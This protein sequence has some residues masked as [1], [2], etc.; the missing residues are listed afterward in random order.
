LRRSGSIPHERAAR[1]APAVRA[2][3]GLLAILPALLVGAF[4]LHSL[5]REQDLALIDARKLASDQAAALGAAIERSLL[6]PPLPSAADLR[7][8]QSRPGSPQR[9]PST[10]AGPGSFAL[11]IASDFAYPDLSDTPPRP[12]PF[13]PESLPAPLARIWR[14]ASLSSGP[15]SLAAWNEL[16]RLSSGTPWEPIVTFR[17]G[18]TLLAHGRT[19]EAADALD[20]PAWNLS[21]IGGV[22][23]LPIDVLAL[24]SLLH[25]A[26]I[27]PRAAPHQREWL[28]AL[29]HRV[30]IRWRLSPA[31]LKDFE[32]LDSERIRRWRAVADRHRELRS[33]FPAIQA[34]DED[35]WLDPARP[36]LLLTTHPVSDG[37]WILLRPE[38]TIRAI[39]SNAVAS[40]SIPPTFAVSALVAGRQFDL[41]PAPGAH[42]LSAPT[43]I[44]DHHGIE[45][46]RAPIAGRDNTVYAVHLALADPDR[47]LADTRR[48]AILFALLIALASALSIFAILAA[49][50]AYD[51]QRRLAA[52]QSDFVASV[53]HELRAPLAS[54]R[55]MT[56]ELTDLPPAEAARRTHYLRLILQQ[57]S[58]LGLLI[59]NVLR[60]ARLEHADSHVARSETDLRTVIENSLESLQPCAADRTVRLESRLPD[61]PVLALGDDQALRQV[62][63]NLVDNALKHSPP[64]ASIQVGLDLQPAPGGPR[65]RLWVTDQGTGI[66]ATEH[67]RIFESFY[68]RGTELRRETS[69]VGLGLAIVR[70]IVA[71]HQ[72]SVSV[73]SMPGAGSRFTVELPG[74]KPDPTTPT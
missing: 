43:H 56:E 10:L 3:V 64:G 14:E 66:P 61:H 40:A 38:D 58:R 72:G 12:E 31:L 44:I 11:L 59:E 16:S 33:L 54:I 53:S 4:G 45:L 19:I 49:L 21:G 23:G 28:D 52:L 42:H 36:P 22:T 1:R 68:R 74:R 6:H 57:T 15:A 71:A 60:H 55:L 46:A 63:V 7:A 2:A 17:L 35:R 34:R 48:R 65:A 18:R 13:D 62:V 41:G 67:E 5:R 9:E 39:L 37:R 69:G 25:L 26:E 30:L 70:R 50:S 47:F 51:R 24:R 32:P 27:D 73:E 20:R 29:C 8:F